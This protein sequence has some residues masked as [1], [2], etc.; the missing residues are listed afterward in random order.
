MTEVASMKVIPIREKK[1]I[2][3]MRNFSRRLCGLEM[4][5]MDLGLK[6]KQLLVLALLL[7]ETSKYGESEREG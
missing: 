7:P 6:L 4:K 1:K 2:P 3:G 5:Y